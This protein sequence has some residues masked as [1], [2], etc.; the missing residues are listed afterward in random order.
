MSKRYQAAIITA[1][2][3]GLLVPN[4]P[5]IGTATAGAGSASVAFTA[6]SNVGGSAITSY[7]AISS[8]G[9]I[10]GTGASSPVT[11][12]GLT[13]GTAYTF[14]V[15]ATN[16]YG[17]GPASAASNSVTPAV[18]Y[19][20][21][22][23]STWLYTGTGAAQTITNGIDLAGKGGLVWTK[24]RN[25]ADYEHNLVCNDVG[26]GKWL[27]SNTT[28]AAQSFAP[29]GYSLPVF[30]TTGVT[31]SD[32]ADQ[33]TSPFNYVSWT[34]R[35]QPKF[36]DVVTYTGD[37]VAGRTV[38]HNLGSVPGCIIVKSTNTVTNWNVYHISLGNT[39]RIFLDDTA[40]PQTTITAW[41]NTSPTSTEFT[42]GDSGQVNGTGNTYVAYLFAHNAGGFGLS[43]NE[44][45]I[46][47]G[48]YTGNGSTSGPVVTLG[49]EPQW[50]MIKNAGNT[51][52]WQIMDNMRGMPVGSAD[53]RLIANTSNAEL[54]NEYVSPTA[55]GFN[56]VSDSGEVNGNG[57][58]MIYIAIRRGPMKVPTDATKV[59]ELQNLD[60]LTVDTLV[61]SAV[62]PDM[63]LQVN[64]LGARYVVSRLTGGINTASSSSTSPRRWLITYDTSAENTGTTGLYYQM[65]N[66]SFRLAGNGADPGSPFN[67]AYFLKRAPGFFDV[68]CYTGTGAGNNAQIHNLTVVPEILIVKNRSSSESGDWY[69]FHTFTAVNFKRQF[70]STTAAE[71]NT[72]YGSFLEAQPTT[73][74]FILNSGGGCNASGTT[75]VAYL[76]ATVA[77]VSKVGSYTGTGALQTVN[78]GFTTGA[79]FV[80]IKRTDSTGDWYVYDS[81]RG[82]TS[83]DDP[84]LFLNNTDAQVTNTNYVD[85]TGVGFQVT[86]A[87]PA[88]LNASGGTYIF[89]AVA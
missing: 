34:F 60:N 61:S 53:Q 2:Y 39:K 51:G 28:Q 21:D 80:L 62:V 57:N 18:N 26:L 55:T 13:N 77:G 49:Y 24:S 76:F 71:S 89:L 35:K 12:S 88:G 72:T 19:I 87:A 36:F 56:L 45:V 73:T 64:N 33:A 9:G 46:S 3:N 29:N 15:V 69:V 27:K 25:T 85:T 78:C 86:A 83:G 10:T 38:A 16:S 79:R 63:A 44:N 58:T 75:Y 65:Q 20:E 41:N 82:I 48:S 47:C 52:S 7:T 22:V 14:T 11:V 1:S 42:L 5:T 43:G 50:L 8:P 31:L 4:A 6:P 37:G 23:F 17:S 59:L 74:N 30:N 40:T 32:S 84:Y 66:A 81:V 68:V 54:T 67:L 70:L